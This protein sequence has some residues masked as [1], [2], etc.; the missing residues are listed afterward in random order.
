MESKR[1]KK[2]QGKIFFCSC[3]ELYSEIHVNLIQN[4][5]VCCPPLSSLMTQNTQQISKY[6]WF[7]L[8]SVGTVHYSKEDSFLNISVLV[9]GSAFKVHIYI[10]IK[11]VYDQCV[12]NYLFISSAQALAFW[13][14]W[15]QNQTPGVP[16]SSTWT[17]KI[18][19]SQVLMMNI[20]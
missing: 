1:G 11:I 2:V 8:S 18:A 3:F 14:Y 19:R 7:V 17:Q 4:K 10:I 9:S 12:R 15:T 5:S 20:S 16:Y 13:E 6:F